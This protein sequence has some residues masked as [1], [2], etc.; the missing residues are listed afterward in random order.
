MLSYLGD[1]IVN[2]RPDVKGTVRSR[3]ASCREPAVPP[4]TPTARRRRRACGSKLLELGPE[5]FAEWIRKQKRLLLTDTTMRDAHQSLLATRVRTLRHAGGRRRRRAPDAGPVQPGDVGRRDVRH[6]D[7]L[8]AGGSVGAAR[9]S[10]A[11]R[12]PNILF[13]ML[14]RASNAV[15]YTNYPDNVVR[16]FIKRSARARHR[17]LPHLRLAE[18]DRRT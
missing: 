7:A 18:L 16:A 2:G 15:G 13:Q 5:K 14:L 10:C 1:V 6:V 8:P 12:V 9:A 11:Q 17:R 4:V 3:S